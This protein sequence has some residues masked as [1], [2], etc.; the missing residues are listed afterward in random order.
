M[1]LKIGHNIKLS[2]FNFTHDMDKKV[3]EQYKNT[4]FHEH[5]Y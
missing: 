1:C 2:K 3:Y 4:L 5:V